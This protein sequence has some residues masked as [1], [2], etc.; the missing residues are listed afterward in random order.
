MSSIDEIIDA[1]IEGRC[2]FRTGRPRSSCPY[3]EMTPDRSAWLKGW[4]WAKFDAQVKVVK[5]REKAS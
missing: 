2:D 3:G 4:D 5:K 1:C